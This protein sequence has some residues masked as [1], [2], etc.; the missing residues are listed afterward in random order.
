M[1]VD[2]LYNGFVLLLLPQE[3]AVFGKGVVQ[4]IRSAFVAARICRSL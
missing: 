1:G 3:Y 2:V 4:W